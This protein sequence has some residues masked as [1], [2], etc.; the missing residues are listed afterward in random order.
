MLPFRI[1]IFVTFI[2]LCTLTVTAAVAQD[3]LKGTVYENGTNIRLNNVFIRDNN[4][5]QVTLTDKNGDFNLKTA[6]GHILIF[7]SPGYNPDTLYLI[8]MR[9]KKIMMV[10]KTINLQQVNV[11][12]TRQAFNPR[13]E[14]RQ[15]YE[16]SKVYVFSPSTWFS[17][18][19][20]DARRLKKYF[21]RDAEEQHIDNVFTPVYVGSI[22]PLKGKELANFISLYRPTYKFL[23]SNNSES[24]VAYINDSYKKY[25]ALPPDKRALPELKAPDTTTP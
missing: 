7:N 23:R 13:V 19:A 14:Y 1:K 2:V 18:E 11:T 5:K 12:A 4:N 6:T 21:Q 9:P 20:K 16:K 3:V 25:Q 22:V 8:D 17:K 10:T 24:L 15:V